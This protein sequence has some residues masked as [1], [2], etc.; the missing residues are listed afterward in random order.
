M[1]PAIP[2]IIKMEKSKLL[3][4]SIVEVHITPKGLNYV[5]VQLTI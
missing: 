3:P 5:L 1:K 4:S 2:F